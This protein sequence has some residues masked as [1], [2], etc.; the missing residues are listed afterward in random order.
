MSNN[1]FLRLWPT[2][3]MRTATTLTSSTKVRP[4]TPRRRSSPPTPQPLSTPLPLLTG[5]LLK[6]SEKPLINLLWNYLLKLNYLCCFGNNKWFHNPSVHFNFCVTDSR[7]G[8]NRTSVVYFDQ[9][10]HAC[11]FHREPLVS[12]LCAWWFGNITLNRATP[13]LS[14]H[15]Q[16]SWQQVNTSTYYINNTGRS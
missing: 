2:P 13:T 9:R 16:Y 4:S 8:Y 12:L 14:L 7:G 10:T 11:I 15:S 5:Q 1:F 3:S 6:W